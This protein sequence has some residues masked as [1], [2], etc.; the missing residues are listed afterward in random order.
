M[1]PWI[2]ERSCLRKGSGCYLK[3]KLKLTF[4]L[5]R[6][7]CVCPPTQW[8]CSHTWTYTNDFEIFWMMTLNMAESHVMAI[9]NMMGLKKMEYKLWKFLVLKVIFFLVCKDGSTLRTLVAFTEDVSF[10][11]STHTWCLTTTY[12]PSSRECRHPLVDT[13]AHTYILVLHIHTLR[14][15]NTH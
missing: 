13:E 14:N 15:T 10:V 5:H 12:D 4:G 1:E 6:L 3:N 7:I 9:P 8:P 2:S 11:P